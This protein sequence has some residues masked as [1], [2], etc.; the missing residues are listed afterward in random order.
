MKYIIISLLLT[1]IN[2][3]AG[4]K[5]PEK[6]FN[7]KFDEII[8][9][10]IEDNKGIIEDSKETNFNKLITPAETA[11]GNAFL[12]YIKTLKESDNIKL[13]IHYINLEFL[14]EMNDILYQ[15][16]DAETQ[17]EAKKLMQKYKQK[18]IAHSLFQAQVKAW[19][20]QSKNNL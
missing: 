13:K 3:N 5:D 7:Q 1:V 9:Q 16:E 20:H 4:V 2:V 8:K 15:L 10:T 6:Y 14:S 19:K 12:D 18:M 11:Y 17:K